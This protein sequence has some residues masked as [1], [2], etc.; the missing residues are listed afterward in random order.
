MA[1]GEQGDATNSDE[2][3]AQSAFSGL[4]HDDPLFVQIKELLLLGKRSEAIKLIQTKLQLDT[5]EAQELSKMIMGTLQDTTI[6][7][8]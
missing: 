4:K 7:P 2:T 1:S 5:P 3:H 8:Q 6:E